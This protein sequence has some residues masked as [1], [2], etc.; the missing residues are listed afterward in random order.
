MMNAQVLETMVNNNVTTFSIF[1]EGEY[2]C[3]AVLNNNFYYIRNSNIDY[4]NIDGK[5][6]ID[7]SKLLKLCRGDNN[8]RVYYL[9]PNSFDIPIFLYNLE[10]AQNGQDFYNIKFEGRFLIKSI[11]L[12]PCIPSPKQSIN[13]V[14][15]RFD[16]LDI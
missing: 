4:V 16:I 9:Q 15:S 13:S 11:V 7:R 12:E 5:I 2:L 14:K 3:Y 10:M 1:Q 8:L 6:C